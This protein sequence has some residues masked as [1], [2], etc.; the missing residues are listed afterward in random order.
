MH[1]CFTENE[2]KIKKNLEMKIFTNKIKMSLIKFLL[3]LIKKWY[4]CKIPVA[5]NPGG[6]FNPLKANPIKWSNTLKQFIAKSRRIV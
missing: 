3:V 6:V 1:E 4:F 5:L 2:N